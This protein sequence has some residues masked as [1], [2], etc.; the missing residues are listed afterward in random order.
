[1]GTQPEPS[2]Q[3]HQAAVEALAEARARLDRLQAS[4]RSGSGL[5][6]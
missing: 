3:E 6:K 5:S 2:A 1:M 4:S